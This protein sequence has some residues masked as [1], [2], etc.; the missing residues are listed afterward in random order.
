MKLWAGDMSQL[1]ECLLEVL[2]PT[3]EL[4]K[5]AVVWAPACNPSTQ[6]AGAGGLQASTLH[7]E[8]LPQASEEVNRT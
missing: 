5:L 7:C 4:S 3:L 2:V 8:T 1:V 6:K